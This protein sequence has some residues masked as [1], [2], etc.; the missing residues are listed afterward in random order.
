MGFSNYIS[1]SE[2]MNACGVSA[3]TLARFAEAGYLTIE[4]ESDGLRLYCTEEL[5]KVFGTSAEKLRPHATNV[6]S[7]PKK[8]AAIFQTSRAGFDRSN[9]AAPSSNTEKVVHLRPTQT[10]IIPNHSPSS[11]YSE[12]QNSPIA[13]ASRTNTGNP[14]GS[15]HA[16]NTAK[17][18]HPK[19]PLR[20]EPS[21]ADSVQIGNTAAVATEEPLKREAPRSEPLASSPKAPDERA[22]VT[23]VD[24]TQTANADTSYL[25]KTVEKL[26]RI[27]EVNEKIIE[28][29]EERIEEITRERDWLRTRVEKLEEKAERDQ[30]LLLSETQLLRQMIEQR[31]NSRSPVRAALEWLG[32]VEPK[33]PN[34][35][36]LEGKVVKEN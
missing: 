29:R 27:N 20:Q 9:L 23:Q 6:K 26:E 1:E 7:S 16:M 3:K 24:E 28:L 13:S 15:A 32:V 11:F 17:Q 10:E 2:A 31:Q 5:K 22:G 19:A 30:V 34:R 25:E 18:T 33:K 35:F 4:K 14:T 12:P 36:R 21:I 8:E